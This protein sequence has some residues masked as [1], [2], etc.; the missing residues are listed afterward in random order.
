V[1][2]TII[3]LLNFFGHQGIRVSK[4]NLQFVGEEIKYLGHLNSKKKCRLGLEKTE[5]IT[6]MPFSETKRELWKFLV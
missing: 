5:G 4:T 1:T 6:G 3:S 2:D